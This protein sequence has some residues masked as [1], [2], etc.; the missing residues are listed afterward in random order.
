MSIKGTVAREKFVDNSSRSKMTDQNR[1]IFTLVENRED[2]GQLHL[3][4]VG[5]NAYN[6]ST[7]EKNPNSWF[8][9][10]RHPR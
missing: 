8:V 6:R 5:E 9:V 2:I 4:Y 7:K 10:I 1:M 3:M